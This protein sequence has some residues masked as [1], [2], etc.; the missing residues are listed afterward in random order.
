MRR[1]SASLLRQRSNVGNVKP[2]PPAG[3]RSDDM[4]AEGC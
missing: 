3:V 1:M 2:I 4:P